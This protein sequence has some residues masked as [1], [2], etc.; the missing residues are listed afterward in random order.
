MKKVLFII[1]VLCLILFSSTLLRAESDGAFSCDSWVATDSLGR[2]LVSF[3]DTG[4]KRDG[5]LVGI[6][7]YIWHGHHG[8]K[9]Y[10]I[11]KL[12]KDNPSAPAWG[13][14]GSFHFW[15][16]PE[17]GYYR[18]EDPWVIRHDL[19]M[20]AIAG[21]DFIFFDVT[22]AVTYLDTVKQLCDIS[23]D[24]RKQHIATPQICF[25]TNAHSGKVM[26]QLY[27]EFY[28]KQLYSDQWFM[29][30][31]KPLIMGH[32]DDPEL[33][34]EVKDFFTIKYSWAWTDTKKQPDH[35]QWLDT[36][37]QDWGWSKKPN[38]PEQITVSTAQHPT[39][40]QGKSLFNGTEP[41]VLSDYTTPVTGNGIQFGQQWQ[42]ALAVDPEIVMVTQWNEWVA[43]R[44]IWENG[45]GT[46]A[47]RPIKNGDSFFVDV[48]S[49]EFN[50]DIAPMKGGHTDN[51][52]YQLIDNIRKFKGMVQP[53]P[54]SP[55]ITINI[56][57]QFSEWESVKP[58]FHDFPGDTAH[59]NFRGY[60][61]AVTYKND[62]GR[63]DII[64][65]RVACDKTKV[66]FLAKTKDALTSY[67][68]ANWMLLY[69]DTDQDHATG[70]QGYDLLV[71]M[72][73]KSNS[74]TVRSLKKDKWEPVLLAEVPIAIKENMLELAIDRKLLGIKPDNAVQIDF[75]WADNIQD[76]GKISEFALNGDSAPDRRFN[77]RYVSK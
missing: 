28:N 34:P 47:G 5:K 9:V 46:F 25:L 20:F 1:V 64:E 31:G 69:I 13:P 12:L 57:G 76:Y 70:W 24:M 39:S 33:R 66:Y 59:R 2:S 8:D 14:G 16:E 10:D 48:F 44:F 68:E 32:V 54:A 15:S 58:I 49:Q 7:Y 53:I 71:N 37:P 18:S 6:F 26:N 4:P 29:R 67:S 21:I 3:E 75:H 77:Y 51:Y 11:A 38:I 22:N 41:A 23:T 40:S 55:M 30:N 61:P 27:D 63:N 45:N 62:T 60:S 52:Y 65:S 42:R 74:T 36:Y 43:Q 73:V 56:D 17:Y 50:R 35:W 72:S 19:Q